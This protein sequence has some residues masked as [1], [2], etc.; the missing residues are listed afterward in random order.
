M[1]PSF[2]NYI[3]RGTMAAAALCALPQPAAAAIDN[4]TAN[5]LPIECGRDC[6]T[7]ALTMVLDAMASHDISKLPLA[8]HVRSSQDGVDIPLY[9]GIW[10]SASAVGKYRL[11]VVDPESGQAGTYATVVEGKK[12]VLLAVRIAT[13]EQKIHEIEIITARDAFMGNAPPGEIMDKIGGPRAQFL[14][15]VPPRER[16]SREDLVH[17]ADSYFSNL[18][19]SRGTT[20]APFAPTCNRLENAMQTTNR[21]N[22]GMTAGGGIDII[23]L[24]CEAQQRSG[25]FPFVTSIRN[26][27][28]PI[29]D[30]ERGIVMAF[31]YFDHTGTVQDI[32]LTTGQKVPSPLATPTTFVMSEAFQIDKGKMDQI[33]AVLR[34]VPYKMR[35]EVFDK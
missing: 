2:R 33:E 22:A 25:F 18:Q 3:Y 29:V 11:N 16:M 1:R 35:N 21:P 26:R 34:T 19:G 30:Q 24:G 10:Q 23:A 7:N 12:T 20:S 32:M 5:V 9:D 14:R 27:R 4:P 8:N 6:L 31:G 17:I 13:K 15:T 28:L